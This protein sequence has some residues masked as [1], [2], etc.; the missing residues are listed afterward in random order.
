M[1]WGGWE[2]AVGGGRRACKVVV[3]TG[4]K[5]WWGCGGVVGSSGVGQGGKE[6]FGVGVMVGVRV[7]PEAEATVAAARSSASGENETRKR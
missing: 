7:T 1:V 6:G 5:V 4:E 3:R 2:E